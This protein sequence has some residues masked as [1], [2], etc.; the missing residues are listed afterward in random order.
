[1]LTSKQE[2]PMLKLSVLVRAVA[3]AFALCLFCGTVASAQGNG[4]PERL[5]RIEELIRSLA[6]EPPTIQ[7]TTRLLFPFVTNQAGFDTGIAVS[8]TGLDSSGTVGSAGTCT[9]HYFGQTT[10]GGATPASQTTNAPIPPGG[11]LAFVLS[12]GGNFGIAGRPNFQGYIEIDCAFPF[13]HG[14]GFLTDGPIGQ[15]R[16]GT[17]IPA[18]VLPTQRI[19]PESAGQ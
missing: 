16:V 13:A 17:T 4:I 10:G 6:P 3:G 15:A 8:N 14:F 7:N 19:A 12:S 2:N 5:S 11:Q 1:M 18:L 9:I